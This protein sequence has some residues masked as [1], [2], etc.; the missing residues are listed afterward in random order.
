[1]SGTGAAASRKHG[2]EV[3]PKPVSDQVI[4]WASADPRAG[5]LVGF[6][7]WGL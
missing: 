3:A 4:L 1:L 6:A 2:V 7:V 5:K